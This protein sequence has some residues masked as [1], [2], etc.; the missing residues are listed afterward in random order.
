[1]QNRYF[2]LHRLVHW[3]TAILV[4]GLLA[5]G[6]VFFFVGF[7]GL[8][9]IF[10]ETFARTLYSYHKAFGIIVLGLALVGIFFRVLFGTPE[11][12]PPLS[13]IF[14]LPSAGVQALM[15]MALVAMPLI[16][17]AGSNAAGRPVQVF[18]YTMP[19]LV[20]QDKLLAENLFWLHDLIGWVLMGLVAIHI[21]AAIVH[22][23]I[24]HD[25]VTERMSL[26]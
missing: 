25:K 4:L 23:K 3:A 5:A 2:L 11:Y 9:A 10:G 19:V 26:L 21:L 1:M 13:A 7:D 24:L 18:D 20:G 15:Y 14:R 17:W 22:S 6:L 8:K 16:G 12:E